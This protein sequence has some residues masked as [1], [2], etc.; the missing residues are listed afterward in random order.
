MPRREVAVRRAVVVEA[1]VWWAFTLGLWCAFVSTI[2]ASELLA[3][4]AAGLIAAFTIV[5]LRVIDWPAF[6]PALRWLAWAPALVATALTDTFGVFADLWRWV[7][8]GDHDVAG[9]RTVA[10]GPEGGGSRAEAH[11]ALAT[12]VVSATPGAYVVRTYPELG[13]ARVHVFG[14]RGRDLVSMVGR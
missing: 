5:Q 12:I 13:E 14:A 10:F 1:L 8:R 6:R 2:S 11:R 3:G 4:T 9:F 7:A